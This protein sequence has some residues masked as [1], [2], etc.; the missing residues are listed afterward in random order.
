MS[1]SMR[2]TTDNA[3][4]DPHAP[5]ASIISHGKVLHTHTPKTKGRFS[6]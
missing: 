5:T 6:A 3:E 4:L 2:G 1:F